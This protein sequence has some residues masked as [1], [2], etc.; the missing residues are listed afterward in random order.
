MRDPPQAAHVLGKLLRYVGENN[1]LW[2]TDCIFY[3]SPQDQI[4]AFRTFHIS[5]EFQER[6]RYPALTP[7]IKAKILGLSGARVYGVKPK[8]VKCH[9]TR[10]QLEEIRRRFP[11]RH[12]TYGPRSAHDPARALG[13]GAAD[14]RSGAG[15][16]ARAA[17]ARRRLHPWQ[18]MRRPRCRPRA[19][20]AATT[21]N[22]PL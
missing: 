2:G 1:I 6:Y 12:Q 8:T 10:R 15:R 5:R 17:R 7:K 11:F 19:R 14:C 21:A 20:A 16:P 4:Q 3:G 22:R 9:F 13:R 18:R